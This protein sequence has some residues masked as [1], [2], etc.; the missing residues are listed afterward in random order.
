MLSCWP[1][2]KQV[3]NPYRTGAPLLSWEQA[4]SGALHLL[5]LDRIN[6][7]FLVFA[8]LATLIPTLTLGWVIYL[9][10]KQQLTE[11]VAAGLRNVG[12]HTIDELDLWVRER[13][14]AL[15][16]IADSEEVST[17]L[18][19]LGSANGPSQATSRSSGYLRDIQARA[20][21]YEALLVVNPTAG[22][23]AASTEE[24]GSVNLPSDWPLQVSEGAP[25]IS[26]TYWDA[27]LNKVVMT[28]AV[29]LREKEG[30]TSGVLAAKLDLGALRETLDGVPY[31]ETGRVVLL[32]PDGT[33]IA[34]S[35]DDSSASR[36]VPMSPTT[37]HA[38]S[39]LEEVPFEYV[40]EL[41]TEVLGTLKRAPQHRWS[42]VSEISRAE[43]FADASRM[44]IVIGLIVV[45]LLLIIGMTAYLMGL[46]IVRPLN[47]LAS[48]A[49]QVAVGNLE[50]D[51]PLTSRGEVGHLTE[52]FNYMV[53]SL[54]QGRA[55]LASINDTLKIKNK[56][57]QELSI[58]DGLTGLYN[59]KHLMETL[60]SE[61]A[62]AQRQRHPFSV[63][64][65]DIDHFKMYNDTFGHLAGDQLLRN[66]AAIFRE[67][68][69]SVDY[70]ARYGG[71]EFMIMLPEH[72]SDAAME[73]AER[74]VAKVAS[75]TSGDET[76]LGPVTLSI[77]LA[78]FPENGDTPEALVTRAD[79]A[80]YQAKRR[81][82]N[83]VV[84]AGVT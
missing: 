78:V 71:E 62:R 7:K 14:H 68:I 80:L 35:G 15:R 41:G 51:L 53:K 59:R 79:A 13:L 52:L 25:I 43:A 64:M 83:R 70:A 10:S 44:G 47:R 73:V 76:D 65:I 2:E 27:A 84:L 72:G 29:P 16:V 58:T 21:E 75:Q 46:T 18:A 26:D 20:S 54:R 31:A 77:G 61:V 19:G 37:F 48:G 5:R 23:I 33:M 22:I 11:K 28:I 56:E 34:R 17:T 81:G 32:A 60:T 3:R 67:S 1:A 12:A 82:R 38:M 57:L 39:E 24:P 45:A 50:V 36:T 8:I 55:E 74:I 49:D 66:I 40:N 30:R 42:V 63:M 6:R 4:I 9:Y 69:R